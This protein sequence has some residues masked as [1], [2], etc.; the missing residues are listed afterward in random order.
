M[1]TLISQKATPSYALDELRAGSYDGYVQG[2]KILG[3]RFHKTCPELYKLPEKWLQLKGTEREQL[4]IIQKRACH[5]LKTLLSSPDIEIASDLALKNRLA[6]IEFFTRLSFQ[7]GHKLTL[8]IYQCIKP[9]LLEKLRSGEKTLSKTQQQTFEKRLANS[10]AILVEKNHSFALPNPPAI[11]PLPHIE[12]RVPYWKTISSIT[13]SQAGHIGVFY[14]HSQA[15]PKDLVVKAPLHPAQECFASRIFQQ[16]GFLTPDTQIIDRK[17]IEGQLIEKALSPSKEFEAHCQDI[18]FTRFF[19]MSRIYGSSIEEIDASCAD[20]AF[21]NDNTSLKALLKQIGMVAAVDS[22][23]HYQ[24]RLPHI[25]F[26]NWGNLM[27]LEHRGRLS[28]A[29]A[30]DQSVDLSKS[31]TFLP[32]TAKAKRALAIAHDV[33]KTPQAT[34]KAARDILEEIPPH[35]QKHIKPSEAL[36]TIQEGLTAGFK[37][38]AKQLTPECLLQIDRELRIFYTD[39]DFVRVK[40]LIDLQQTIRHLA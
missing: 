3:D 9:H 26:S 30:I 19:I 2:L 32:S 28:F 4:I 27:S 33:L 18:A 25:G 22:L 14:L 20:R 37:A 13:R 1:S 7:Y 35:I 36:A 5:I 17:S 21:T 24:D 38:I 39:R 12:K 6:T 31:T 23:L 16:L 10:Q 8:R 15:L 11:D 40:D 29:V 34:S